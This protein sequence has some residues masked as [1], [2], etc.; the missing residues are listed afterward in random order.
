VSSSSTF[1]LQSGC[2]CV[3]D[4]F[5]GSLAE[6]LGGGGWYQSETVDCEEATELAA[7]VAAGMVQ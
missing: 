3:I 2:S 5:S 7:Q 4:F 1:A 6:N